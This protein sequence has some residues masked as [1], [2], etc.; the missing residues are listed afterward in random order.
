MNWLKELATAQTIAGVLVVANEYLEELPESARAAIPPQLLP[1]AIRS[2]DELHQ[3]HQKLSDSVAEQA[4][5]ASPPHLDLCVFLLRAA[6]RAIELQKTTV[7]NGGGGLQGTRTPE[8]KAK[9]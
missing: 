6:A 5:K 9:G 2:E 7:A 3:W 8:A 4:G 1:L